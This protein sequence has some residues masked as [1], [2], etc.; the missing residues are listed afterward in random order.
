MLNITI[1]FTTLDDDLMINAFNQ[2]VIF[3]QAA[4]IDTWMEPEAYK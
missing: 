2:I 1:N 4:Q 3:S